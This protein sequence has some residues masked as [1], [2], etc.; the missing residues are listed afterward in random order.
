MD[1]YESNLQTLLRE[2]RKAKTNLPPSHIK[3]LAFQ[4]FKGLFY[5]KVFVS[6]IKNN[7]VCHRDL[8]P[9][10]ILINP[11]TLELRICDFGSAKIFSHNEK[12][13]SYICSRFYRAP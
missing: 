8:K 11:S 9:P 3:I 4:L 7:N 12:N 13:V 6:M 10:N 2:H 5:L 1:L